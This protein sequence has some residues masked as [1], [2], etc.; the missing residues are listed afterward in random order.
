MQE[1]VVVVPV[2]GATVCRAWLQVTGRKS[3]WLA[4]QLGVD[5]SLVSH[6][7]AGRRQ[8]P[9]AVAE[10]IERLSDGAVKGGSWSC[11]TTSNEQ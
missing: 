9:A 5:A 8:P 1:Q 11:A 6:W 3:V 10:A 4:Q 7:L 2:D